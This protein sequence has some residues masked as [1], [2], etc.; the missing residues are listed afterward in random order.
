MKE[1]N[2]NIP[3]YILSF[4]YL[5][6]SILSKEYENITYYS[7]FITLTIKGQG[8]SQIFYYNNNNEYC[9]TTSFPDEVHINNNQQDNISSEYYFNES[10]NIIKL[11]YY[12]NLTNL[13]CMFYTCKNIIEMDFSNF[14]SSNIN[15]CY[16]LFS[17]CK[18]L[19][20]INFINFNTSKVQTMQ[21]MFR[22]CKVL[23]SLNLSNF[24]T[25]KVKNTKRMFSDCRSLTSIN[26]SNFDLSLVTLMSYMFQ[27][28]I[29]LKYVEFSNY[30]T[31]KL[32]YIGSLFKNCPKLV[33]VDLSY[34][35]TSKVQNMDFTFYNCKTLTSLNLSN[36]DTS[37]V[38]WIQ[39]MFDSCSNLQ[40]LNFK[41]LKENKDPINYLN[42]FRGIPDNIVICINETKAP[43]IVKL[44]KNKFC[45][46]IDCSE[47]WNLNKKI[48]IN[49]TNNC[50][51]TCN[52]DIKYLYGYKYKYYNKCSNLYDINSSNKLK[53]KSDSEDFILYSIIDNNQNLCISCND[54]FNSKEPKMPNFEKYID[55]NTN[56]EG[57][58]LN[59]SNNNNYIYK[60]CFET[61][62]TCEIQGNNINHNCLLCN[63]YFPFSFRNNNYFNCYNNCIYYF[64]YDINKS[65]YYCTNDSFCPNEYNKLKL[66]KKECIKN[67]SL[68]NEYKYEFEN[69]CYKKCPEKSISS[70]DNK[71]FCETLCNDS[72]P[73]LIIKTQECVDYC[74]INKLKLR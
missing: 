38:T 19:T 20:S 72:Y 16:S 27:N 15:S 69:I 60:L 12:D 33:S 6:I 57:Y 32:E 42:M 54:L 58:Y 23:S 30:Y 24:D 28:C 26:L 29:N 63:D 55:C 48:I 14:D 67:C 34:F 50:T 36:F 44:I 45:H 62:K 31:N 70:D 35:I 13:D 52:N 1:K 43:N 5:I 53:C 9:P 22:N 74:D 71:Y 66:E 65:I 61:C 56:P 7:S 25:S 41:N 8:K 73:F 68:D 17:D 39:S 59:E 11:V 46:S 51:Y 18:S 2:K 40:Y 3:L 64:Y 21:N 10:T 47:D 49:E 37:S 4:I